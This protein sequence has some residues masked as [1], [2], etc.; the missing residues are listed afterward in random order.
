[1]ILVFDHSRGKAGGCIYNKDDD[2][3]NSIWYLLINRP[4]CC[5]FKDLRTIN[6]IEYQTFEEAVNS[7]GLHCPRNI[8]RVL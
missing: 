5:S 4:E 3:L 2:E 1:L 8:K 6:G 7:T